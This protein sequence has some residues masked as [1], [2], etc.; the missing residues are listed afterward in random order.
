MRVCRI[1]HLSASVHPGRG[2]EPVA[3][4]CRGATRSCAAGA[5]TATWARSTIDLQL[6]MGRFDTDALLADA[7]VAPP[8]RAESA[9]GSSAWSRHGGAAHRFSDEP[10]MFAS[11]QLSA[12][13]V[14]RHCIVRG[15]ARS[16]PRDAAEHPVLTARSLDRVLKVART[17]ADLDC[18]PEIVEAL[19]HRALER[20]WPRG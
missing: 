5:A 2:H 6:E 9:A 12:R 18:A 8:A 11:R 1:D 19:Q 13:L 3:V 15:A 4:R 16:L 10:D 14:R 17:I 20:A 7:E